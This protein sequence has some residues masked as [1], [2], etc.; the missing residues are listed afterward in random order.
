M[1]RVPKRLGSDTDT[2]DYLS[3]ASTYVFVICR[4]AKDGGKHWNWLESARR[5][6]GVREV[7]DA[8]VSY[9]ARARSFLGKTQK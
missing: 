6:S 4:A 1:V 9:L 5:N 7:S 2:A 8:W 3:A